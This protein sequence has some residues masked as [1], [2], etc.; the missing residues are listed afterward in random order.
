[1][2]STLFFVIILKLT[3]FL[4]SVNV[5]ILMQFI[6]STKNNID[7]VRVRM[8]PLNVIMDELQTDI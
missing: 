3:M 7:Q 4:T 1:M 2:I 8:N 6:F 5:L